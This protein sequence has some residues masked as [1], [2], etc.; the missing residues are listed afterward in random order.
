M[1]VGR[2]LA[3]QFQK[4]SEFQ[5][6]QRKCDSMPI[7]AA[8]NYIRH[9]YTAHL[10]ARSPVPFHLTWLD[11]GKVGAKFLGLLEGKTFWSSSKTTTTTV[12]TCWETTLLLWRGEMLFPRTHLDLTIY[13]LQSFCEFGPEVFPGAQLHLNSG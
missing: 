11:V 8:I 10:P 7:A 5:Q 3:V 13:L 6:V 9:H 2:I 4:F 1:V 12:T